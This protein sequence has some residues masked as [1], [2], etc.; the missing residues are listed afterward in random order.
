MLRFI[1]ILIWI[2]I[3]VTGIP[4]FGQIVHHQTLE[5]PKDERLVEEKSLSQDVGIAY[6]ED[7]GAKIY[8]FD[9]NTFQ[10]HFFSEDSTLFKTIDIQFNLDQTF[11]WDV[12]LERLEV[13]GLSQY[14]FDE[15]E[16][17]EFLVYMTFTP[18]AFT[19]YFD[20]RTRYY[21][22]D[23]DGS[24]LFRARGDKVKNLPKIQESTEGSKMFIPISNF[25]TEVFNLPGKLPGI[26]EK[27]EQESSIPDN[28]SVGDRI[29]LDRIHFD[30]SSYRLREDAIPELEDLVA[31]MLINP[32][33]V[34]LLEGHT[35][36]Q[37]GAQENMELSENRVK[38]IKEYLVNRGIK[39]KRIKTKGYGQTQPVASNETEETRKLNRRVEMEILNN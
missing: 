12:P 26:E 15:D 10:I 35:D 24:L 21:V 11:F 33:M 38:V 14:L 19:R 29:T 37:G 13:I 5:T 6:F 1:K 9:F 3:T 18:R 17:I 36:N 7:Y 34:I 20:Q 27:K 39:G 25:K 4:I 30:Q 23:E 32:K 31:L 8:F 28:L 22:V 16:G 2:S